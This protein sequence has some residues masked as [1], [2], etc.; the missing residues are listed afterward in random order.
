[1][2]VF[3]LLKGIADIVYQLGGEGYTDMDRCIY[4]S[5]SSVCLC[6]TQ[7]DT[8]GTGHQTFTTGDRYIGLAKILIE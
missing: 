2:P 3:D 7:Y 8:A 6:R 1:M 4:R 5:R